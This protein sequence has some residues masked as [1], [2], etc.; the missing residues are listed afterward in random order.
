MKA[1]GL[2]DFLRIPLAIAV[3]LVGFHPAAAAAQS[4]TVTATNVAMPANG[5][6]STSQITLTS[7]G[8]YTGTI[9]VDCRYAGPS[10]TANLP[11]CSGYTMVNNFPLTANQTITIMRPFYP[12]GVPIPV[13]L[14]VAPHRNSPA[15]LAGLALAGVFLFSRRLCRSGARWLALVLLAAVTM[16]GISACSGAAPMVTG[17]PGIY[18]YAITGTD[19]STNVTVST[20]ILVTV[21]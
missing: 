10:T 15:P 12:Y 19:I 1:Y 18:T 16:A 11:I 5:A 8:G 21:P 14:P 9:Y 4:F 6:G 2:I 20:T 7:V 13:R 17:T 3:V